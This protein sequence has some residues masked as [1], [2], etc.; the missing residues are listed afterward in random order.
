MKPEITGK[1]KITLVGI[2][3]CR[4]PFFEYYDW[5]RFKAMDAPDN[6]LDIYVPGL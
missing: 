1:R 6:E 3:L 2:D 5:Q 4:D